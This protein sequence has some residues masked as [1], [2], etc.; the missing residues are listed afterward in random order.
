[1]NNKTK[2]GEKAAVAETQTQGGAA[3]ERKEKN[4]V[5]Q[6]LDSVDWRNANTYFD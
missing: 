1:M 4:A 2:N 6:L 5:R 3:E